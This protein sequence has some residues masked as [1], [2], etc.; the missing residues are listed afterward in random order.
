MRNDSR[1]AARDADYLAADWSEARL[2]AEVIR[3]LAETGTEIDVQGAEV[4]GPLDL[5]DATLASRLRF[6]RCLFREPVDV[7]GA[8]LVAL[9]LSGS[10][11]PELR[12]ARLRC[13]VL[14]FGDRGVAGRVDIST[15]ELGHISFTGLLL[16]GGRRSRTRSRT[17][18]QGR[19]SPSSTREC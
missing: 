11:I 10:R 7:S 6:R 12:A 3:W 5:P 19:R 15:A 9:D 18:N 13:D 14:T 4:V 17:R 2:R 16:E 8:T 1:E